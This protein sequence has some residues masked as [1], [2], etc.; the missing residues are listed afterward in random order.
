[1]PTQLAG[2]LDTASAA[3]DSAPSHLHVLLLDVAIQGRAVAEDEVQL[4]HW[5]AA[6]VGAEHDAVGRGVA[7]ALRGQVS[8]VAEELDVS[9]AAG[10]AVREAH[11]VL[12]HQ[13]LA[14]IHGL[15]QHVGQA[16]MLALLDHLQ[17]VEQ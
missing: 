14:G 12:K 7:E 8:G 6:L 5:L 15:G 11:L 17:R 9:A 3:S 13:A 10:D 4:A 1:M 2:R 16:V